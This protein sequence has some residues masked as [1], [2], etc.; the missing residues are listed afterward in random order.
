MV[1]IFSPLAPEVKLLRLSELVYHF[2]VLEV[3]IFYL[4]I[5]VMY[6]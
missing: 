4:N 2:G 3:F 1:F 5:F 6:K